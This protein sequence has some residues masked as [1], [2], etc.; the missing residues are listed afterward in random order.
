MNEEDPYMLTDARP[1]SRDMFTYPRVIAEAGMCDNSVDYAIRVA[2]SA[3]AVDCW[4]FKVQMLHPEEVAAPGAVPYDLGLDTPATQ[5][6]AFDGALPYSAWAEV[7][8]ACDEF[9]IEFLASCWDLDAVDALAALGASW[10]KVGSGDITHRRMLRRISAYPFNV[11]LSTGASTPRE[12]D[13]AI[14][15]L[16]GQTVPSQ[17]NDLVLMICTL[18]YPCPLSFAG[19]SRIRAFREDVPGLVHTDRMGYSDHTRET[20]TAALAVAAGADYLE[21]H[22]TLHPGVGGGDH[23]FALGPDDMDTYVQEAMEAYAVMHPDPAML[24]EL[25]APARRGAR[26][27]LHAAV[28][29][30]PGTHLGDAIARGDARWLRPWV[31]NGISA[32]HEIGDWALT[33]A[34]EA[35]SPILW[36][37]IG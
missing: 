12:A 5:R 16:D 22:F 21:K 32:A 14:E 24:E 33:R 27:S 34:V 8:A 10:I 19:L 29:L 15:C 11:I 3:A 30:P 28:D 13:D 37:V 23:M 31:V 4:G 35:G 9:G 20:R 18:A 6:E 36:D 2:E 26:R 1:A 17:V 25:E 7:K